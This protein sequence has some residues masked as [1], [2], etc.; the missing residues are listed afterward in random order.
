MSLRNGSNEG[1][2]WP[3]RRQR[4]CVQLP[5][6]P[7]RL[8]H[9]IQAFFGDALDLAATQRPCKPRGNEGL[10]IP[11]LLGP[12]RALQAASFPHL[13]ATLVPSTSKNLPELRHCR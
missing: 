11:G 4:L 13:A 5:L 7:S 9:P 8:R 12:Q 1:Q 10:G 6:H 3:K 2:K